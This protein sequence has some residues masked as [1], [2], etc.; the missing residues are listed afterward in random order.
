MA[1]EDKT[2][3]DPRGALL[4][5]QSMIDISADRLDGLRTQ[6]ATSAE[7]TQ[8]EIRTLEGKLVKL[9]SK[10]L[11]NKSSF[12]ENGA[13]R[14]NEVINIPPLDQWLKVVGLT[15]DSITGLCKRIS[16]LEDLQLKSD[17]ELRG[18]LVERQ[19]REEDIR[20]LIRSLDN[21]KR[22]I[23]D[24]KIRGD[25]AN[26]TEPPLYWD[27]W[28]HQSPQRTPT[29]VS[30][31]H[32]R[33]RA[34]R[35]SVP[36]EDCFPHNN[37]NFSY[38]PS[39]GGSTSSS[40]NSLPQLGSS[41]PTHFPPLSPP[42]LPIYPPCTPPST[43]PVNKGK[44]E[45]L[46][47]PT[48]PPP[49]RKIHG[50]SSAYNHSHSNQI[51][52]DQ[53][54]QE[55]KNLVCQENSDQGTAR[56]QP[57]YNPF[58][59]HH[60]QNQHLQQQQQ[61]QHQQHQ[62]QQ[63]QHQ[64]QQQQQHQQQQHQQQQ[65]QQQQHQQQQ[66]QQH[67]QSQQ[68]MQSA[69]GDAQ[70]LTKSKS[71]E[72]QLGNRV[73]GAESN[74]SSD[75]AGTANGKPFRRGRLPTEPGPNCSDYGQ[76]S[77]L[78][79]SP[80]KSPPYSTAGT[81]SD[82]NSAKSSL[83]VPKSP[84]PA[85]V[86]TRGMAHDI[87]HRFTKTYKM[88]AN[89]DYCDKQ[90]FMGLKCTECK[91]KCHKD[92]K[93]K[94][95]PSCG[96][97][98]ALVEAFR[99]T[100]KSDG[101]GPPNSNQ[102]PSMRRPSPSH[103]LNNNFFNRK[104]R[105]RSHPQPSIQIPPFQGPDSS[106]N[107]SSC[108]SSTPSSPAMMLQHASSA[109]PTTKQNSFHF[110]EVTLPRGV[111]LETHPLTA[112]PALEEIMEKA[113]KE[114]VSMD[115]DKT[116]SVSGSGSISTDSERTPVRVDSQDSQVSDGEATD[117][118]G[119][120]RQNSLSMREWDI[121][122][123][124]LNLG[125]PLGTGHFGTVYRGSWYGDVAIK[126]LNMDKMDDTDMEK[127]LEAFKLEVAIFRKTRHENLVLFMGACMKPPRLAIVTSMCKG[128]T[129][130]THIHIR[131][132]KFNMNRTTMV[133]QQISQGMGYLHARGIIH[134]DLKSKNIFLQNGKV[135][136]TDFGL[137]SVTKLCF[138]NRK[139]K[140]LSIPRGWLC[141]LAP[142]IM[143]SLKAQQ[144]Q[145]DDELPFSK[146]SDVYAFG[147]VWYELLCGEW[148]FKAQPPESIIWQVGK[149]MKQTLANL[150]ASR[151]VKAPL[152]PISP[153][154]LPSLRQFAEKG[155][156]KHHDRH[157]HLPKDT[158]H[159]ASS[160]VTSLRNLAEQGKPKG[161]NEWHLDHLNLEDNDDDNGLSLSAE[162]ILMSCWSYKPGD[163]PDFVRLLN[164]FE[165]L[166]KKRLVR[167]PSHPIQLSRSAES[168]F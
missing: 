24:L 88:I 71:H 6:C 39:L 93:S 100:L 157:Y 70:T 92:C 33:Q 152:F 143:C 29:S 81:D 164:T 7:L 83:Q 18:M 101:M 85:P 57:Q 76:T 73:E 32:L 40:V 2:E 125:D 137:F 108:N 80:I 102:S 150:Q 11:L 105:K 135:V 111:T 43:P 55:L 74:Q 38:S 165:K 45:K 86:L 17:N 94:V 163:R 15:P 109:A 4:V 104:D 106:S 140:G 98:R 132:D 10:L 158:S 82:D 116:L 54:V 160:E 162:D 58:Q 68:Q 124:D 138:G 134:K 31:R 155:K 110:P 168:V 107:T 154:P 126:V 36:S 99:A 129:L 14:A 144:N 148:P 56:Y 3:R 147:T 51:S 42:V 52:Q 123:D 78:L 19:A 47:F 115:S 63:H 156:P 35:G 66:Q 87:A 139:G 34:T 77:P 64:Q 30:P 95:P 117:G 50:N 121:P 28:E 149:G 141:Y 49:R 25:E 5:V 84:R 46:R 112:P 118:K 20:R 8:Q 97:P 161:L 159:S 79:S 114:G 59:Q 53:L 113:Q 65:H 91:Y 26:D 16:T 23:Q 130:Y 133:A 48:T 75:A 12:I 145:L 166:P 119:W 90:M 89:C 69:L 67:Q 44:G 27:S 62:H 96:L 9:Y 151:D 136:I 61:H 41:T 120:P 22:Y 60:P 127:T 1:N 72:F 122:F 142:E 153:S 37:N 13:L 146:A 167:S 103:S 128:L 131:K 21:L